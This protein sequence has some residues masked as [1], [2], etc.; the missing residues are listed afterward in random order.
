[1]SD[2][3]CP[4]FGPC[5]EPIGAPLASAQIFECAALRG[6]A[7]GGAINKKAASNSLPVAGQETNLFYNNK[8]VLTAG[9]ARAMSGS[10]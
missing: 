2:T 7:T 4:R 3:T 6:E 5:R 1:M 10:F 8:F 9:F